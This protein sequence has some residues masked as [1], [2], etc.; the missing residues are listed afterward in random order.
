MKKVICNI[1]T[2][3]MILIFA[4]ILLSYINVIQHNMQIG[5]VYPTW[6]LFTYIR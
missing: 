1:A 2:L 3:V 5:Y 4:W 6:N